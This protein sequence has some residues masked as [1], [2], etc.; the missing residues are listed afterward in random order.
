MKVKVRGVA[1]NLLKGAQTKKSGDG[2]PQRGPGAQ[3]L[4]G[5]GSPG[6]E[7]KPPEAG[8]KCG[9]DKN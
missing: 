9:H 7:A 4:S 3:T 2:S 5:S 1:R 6:L 8:D